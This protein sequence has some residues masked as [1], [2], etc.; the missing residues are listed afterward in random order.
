MEEFFRELGKYNGKTYVHEA[1]SIDEFLARFCPIP[2]PLTC[3][4]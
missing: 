3:A 4:N 2:G 1:F